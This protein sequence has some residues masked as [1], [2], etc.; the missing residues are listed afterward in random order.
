[1]NKIS[2][3][4]RRFFE[5]PLVLIFAFLLMV[6]IMGFFVLRAYYLGYLGNQTTLNV[7]SDT[8][9]EIPLNQTLFYK[10]RLVLLKDLLSN[11]KTLLIFWAIWC[12]PCIEE[13]RSMPSKLKILEEKGYR[14]V[15]INYDSSE[16][17][18]KAQN[19]ISSYGLDTAFEPSGQLL[20]DLGISALPTSLVVD[21]TGKIS[22]VLFGILDD[23]NL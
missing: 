6:L 23:K 1:M 15:F 2:K 3:K 18:D 19:F 11:E 22:K 5:G 4:S 7:P 20:S 16:N 12:Q 8:K 10:N 9:K 21:K 13:I 14:V 17:K